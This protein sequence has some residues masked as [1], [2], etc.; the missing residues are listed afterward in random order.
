VT[1]KHKSHFMRR[2][3][4][5][6]QAYTLDTT[7]DVQGSHAAGRPLPSPPKPPVAK[8]VAKPVVWKKKPSPK[9]IQML[10]DKPSPANASKFDKVFGEGAAAATLEKNEGAKGPSQDLREKDPGE[11]QGTPARQDSGGPAL[12]GGLGGPTQSPAPCVIGLTQCMV[13]LS[14]GDRTPIRRVDTSPHTTDEARAVTAGRRALRE[15]CFRG[16]APLLPCYGRC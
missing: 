4:R 13:E 7:T 5:V 9:H 3:P 8:T 6:Y 16:A 10:L 15:G 14:T 11:G 12:E 1:I 2:E